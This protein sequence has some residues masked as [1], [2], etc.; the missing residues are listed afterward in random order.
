MTARTAPPLMHS[1][2][3][4]RTCIGFILGRHWVN[5]LAI[6]YEGFTADEQSLGVFESEQDAATA[7]WR[8]ARG[9]P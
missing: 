5:N 7:L 2:Y 4:G 8:H 3:D 6:A 1:V 9:Q